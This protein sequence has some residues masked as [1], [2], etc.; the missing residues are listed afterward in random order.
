[1]KIGTFARVA[2]WAVAFSLAAATSLGVVL[3]TRLLQL[4]V[5]GGAYGALG[6]VGFAIVTAL[7][8]APWWALA[9]AMLQWDRRRAARRATPINS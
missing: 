9:A 5:W 6:I 4:H 3:M 2:A 7:A 1:M 8:I